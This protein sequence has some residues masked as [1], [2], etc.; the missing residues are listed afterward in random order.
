MPQSLM[1]PHSSLPGL[2]TIKK[3]GQGTY[4]LYHWRVD[5]PTKTAVR[6]RTSR[7]QIWMGVKRFEKCG[8]VQAFS[9]SMEGAATIPF[10]R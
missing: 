7:Q 5:V 8:S 10:H 4:T 3:T 9:Y 1:P 6:G 2:P